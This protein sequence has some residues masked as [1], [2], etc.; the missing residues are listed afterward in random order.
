MI[1][2]LFPGHWTG[3][4]R[5]PTTKSVRR[6]YCMTVLLQD[7]LLWSLV[8]VIVIWWSL[9]WC[10]LWWML[11]VM[12]ATLLS[13]AVCVCSWSQYS[14]LCHHVSMRSSLFRTHSLKSMWFCSMCTCVFNHI[15]HELS[16]IIL[17][18]SVAIVSA[19]SSTH[20]VKCSFDITK[21][22][23]ILA[24]AVLYWHVAWYHTSMLQRLML[25]SSVEY[26][27]NFDSYT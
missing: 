18:V 24:H 5:C 14:L 16:F 1:G 17:I 25:L 2:Q 26:F 23:W 19:P 20:W 15:L 27:W 9:L 8:G 11:V 13:S 7:C 12:A 3:N 6:Y 22:W 21:C 4:R 10:V